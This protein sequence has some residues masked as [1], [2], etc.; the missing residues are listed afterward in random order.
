MRLRRFDRLPQ[1][2]QNRYVQPYYE[3]LQGR[4][5]Q[6]TAKRVLDIM[7]SG[8]LLFLLSPL[9][10]GIGAAVVADSPGS[11]VFL[12]RRVT[13][14]GRCFRIIKFRT[15]HVGAAGAAVTQANDPRI[16]RLG[17]LL[18]KTKLDELPQLF[19]VLCGDMTLVGPRPE[20]PRLVRC[21]DKRAA[22]VLL[23]PA[24]MTGEASVRFRDEASLLQGPDPERCYC[25]KILP[26]KIRYDLSYLPKAGPA[27]DLRLLCR[28]A[29]ALLEEGTNGA[30]G[31]AH[32]MK[33]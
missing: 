7:V 15:M 16:T 2:M 1:A 26:Q 33:G 21:Y 5:I 3:Q 13:Q 32:R 11:P 6:L 12:Q 10:L 9:M 14:Y 29:Q 17:R 18:R 31:A 22:A 28:T 19:N 4:Q 23:L 8:T 20:L 25:E 27:E 30:S 24:G